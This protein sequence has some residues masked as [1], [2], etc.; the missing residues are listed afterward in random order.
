MKGVKKKYGNAM[1]D[2]AGSIEEK[3]IVSH[4]S[5]SKLLDMAIAD[6]DR[7]GFPEGRMIEL[8]GPESSGKCVTADTYILTPGGYKTVETIFKENNTPI[9][10]K[11]EEVAAE[12]PLI[13]KDGDVENTYAITFN[14][15]K[16]V[17]QVT[18]KHGFT[19]KVTKNHPLLV[20]DE[21]VETKDLT[22]GQ[23]LSLL[24]GSKA[25]NETERSRFDVLLVSAVSDGLLTQR[26]DETLE[27]LKAIIPEGASD[28]KI[29][30]TEKEL[31]RMQLALLNEGVIS[32][33]TVSEDSTLFAISSEEIHQ[34]Y[35]NDQTEPTVFNDA[36][37][38]IE[39]IGV[40]PTFDV[41]MPETQ[42][43]IGN[44][45][46]NHNTTI[47]LLAIAERQ[48]IENARAEEDPEYE[49]K[50]SVFMDAE[51]ALDK[52][53]AVDYGVD[54]DELIIIRPD[55]AEDGMD[56][57]DSYI[58]T[59]GVGIAVIDSVSALVP[60]QIEQSSFQQQTMA[61]LARFMGQV[62]TRLS[63]PV[64]KS[65]TTLL[66]INQIR[67]QVGKWSPTGSTPETT[68]GGRALKFHSTLRI[69]VR[70]GE[71]IGE[72]EN[73]DGHVM[74][75]QIVK[76]K[77]A[78][79]FRTASIKLYYGIGIDT[80]EEIGEM[81]IA[82]GLIHQGGSWF[83]VIDK[84]TGELLQFEGEEANYQGR[85]KLLEAIEHNDELRE[86]IENEIMQLGNVPEEE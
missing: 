43:F 46:I 28:F 41:A 44:G 74:N 73:P 57:L 19:I 82:Y 23:P 5:G 80:I 33:V 24:K 1:S 84:E 75:V 77:I 22:E 54:L 8:F 7:A 4:S 34:L 83:K 62:S 64:W 86:Y 37:V 71:T 17:L 16:E 56:I 53:L 67:E 13:N 32:S 35:N 70:R 38:S 79:P 15:E 9:E 72:R 65:G 66:F 10:T 60:S 63:G 29:K 6:G 39:T 85:T 78:P 49:K 21:W 50:I 27:Y 52:E 76:N 61:V 11:E 48:K 47:A 81:A 51:F 31:R 12:I 3:E 40:E 45:L 55:Q 25:Y 58:R 18:T 59:G 2:F 69:R 42:S 36:I 68:P 26:R 14:G 20:N 30:G